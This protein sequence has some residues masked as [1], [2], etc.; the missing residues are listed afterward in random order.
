MSQDAQTSHALSVVIPVHNGAAVLHQCLIAL[1]QSTLLPYECIVVDD[2]ST[3]E[4]KHIVAKYGARI[5]SLQGTHGPA[6]ARN[7]GVEIAT[8]SLV[9]FLDADVCVHADTL[10]KVVRY[11]NSHPSVDAIFGSYDDRPA[12][13]GFVSQYKNLFHHYIHQTAKCQAST[14]WAGCGAIKREVFL[15]HGGFDEVYRRPCIEDIELGFRLRTSGRTI[16]LTKEIQVT[17]LKRWT[18]WALVRTDILDRAIPWTLL[19]LRDKTVPVDLNLRASHQ[20]SVVILYGLLLLAVGL[21]VWELLLPGLDLRP[22]GTVL[23]LLCLVLILL[24]Y[25]LYVFLARKRDWRFATR[26]LPIHWLYYLYSGG[27]VA[28]ALALHLLN[29]RLSLHKQS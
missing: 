14:F 8:G 23:A 5:L 26:A 6:Y 13:R 27:A 2:G 29:G 12:D 11:F 21:P 18:L 4:S 1:W 10:E 15:E 19:M 9:L 28:A 3:D 20:L 25:K 22:V 24:N 16:H 17:H 7:R